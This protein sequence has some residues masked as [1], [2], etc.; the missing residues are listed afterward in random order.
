MPEQRKQGEETW[1][2]WEWQRSHTSSGAQEGQNTVSPSEGPVTTPPPAGDS[3]Q[4]YAA[5]APFT[6]VNN[7]S[8]IS[9]QPNLH[10]H[11]PAQ[12]Y[13]Q[14]PFPPSLQQGSGR[15]QDNKKII[16]I[17]VSALAIVAL[18]L[19][20]LFG[21]WWSTSSNNTS[22]STADHNSAGPGERSG[23]EA[24]GSSGE[25]D[26]NEPK[27]HAPE[28]LDWNGTPLSEC[29]KGENPYSGTCAP[30]GGPSIPRDINIVA[31]G[32]Y[33]YNL[34][35]V[36]GMEDCHAIREGFVE[37]VADVAASTTHG[38]PMPGTIDLIATT[39]KGSEEFSCQWGTFS[40]H[41]PD[42]KSQWECRSKDRA[43]QIWFD[44]Q[45]VMT[46]LPSSKKVV[47]PQ[48]QFTPQDPDWIDRANAAH[49]SR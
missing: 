11:N 13:Q 19:V 5:N 35:C 43:A 32:L 14:P 31:Q 21:W 16:M 36:N 2:P 28:Y 23:A 29:T 6:G 3:F 37:A 12:S 15:S 41:T 4:R 22:S 33:V 18:L 8:G 7:G 17:L 34:S 39:S 9:G 46:R 38:D 40:S 10:Y 48:Q 47:P 49:N 30:A 26:S 44:G 20:G 1:D 25:G 45:A 24:G 27:V 42:R